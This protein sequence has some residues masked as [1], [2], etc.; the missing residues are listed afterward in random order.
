MNF[1]QSYPYFA[2]PDTALPVA[3]GFIYIGEPDT[4]PTVE[5][6]RITV[7]L[8]EQDGTEVEIL[9]AAQP[10]ETGDGGVIMYDGSPVAALSVETNYSMTVQRSDET[11]AYYNPNAGIPDLIT[12]LQTSSYTYLNSVSGTDVITAALSPVLSAYVVGAIYQGIA[13]ND[14]TG[15]TTLNINSLGA[16]NVLYNG[17]AL[18]AGMIKGGSPFQVE[19][20]DATPTFGLMSIANI[21]SPADVD[22]TGGTINDTTIGLT[23]PAAAAFTTLDAEAGGS[24]TAYAVGVTGSIN[25]TTV[26]NIGTG[27]DNLMTYSLAAD[28]FSA[29][30]D[31]IEVIASGKTA[32]NANAKT[33]AFLFGA[34]ALTKTM[35]AS[36]EG[37]WW[38]HGFVT[39]TANNV[40]AISGTFTEST[41]TLS[42]TDKSSV[43]SGVA[44][45]ENDGGA[46]TVKFTGEGT[47]NDDITQDLMIV[48]ILN[49]P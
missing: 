11:Q 19:V 20:L 15:A 22:I 46:I 10:L 21:Q 29:N 7:T 32:N 27:T 43:N 49:A 18:T 34:A 6:N 38:F 42:A 39:R 16:G 28:T 30:G 5:G 13:A 33:L 2:D 44:G 8:I 26:G 25:A 45:S 9:P 40:Q 36:I 35:T 23:T 4:D 12:N 47:S 3:N 14:N 48:R 31:T 24:G 37:R 1:I 41:I 17:A